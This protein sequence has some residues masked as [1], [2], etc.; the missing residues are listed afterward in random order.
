MSGVV[1][2]KDGAILQQS[3][4][5]SVVQHFAHPKNKKLLVYV[6]RNARLG[7]A[8]CHAV[9][10]STG[11]QVAALTEAFTA[12]VT[13]AAGG[14]DG[15]RAAPS[16]MDANLAELGSYDDTVHGVYEGRFLGTV[17]VVKKEGEDTVSAAYV[18]AQKNLK[19]AREPGRES[20]IIVTTDGLR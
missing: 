16:D 18:Q 20:I 6:T 5:E 8:Y 11:A 12:G 7:V 13:A 9:M 15:P 10:A 2:M 19:K 14:A 17:P 3:P 1:S 4:L